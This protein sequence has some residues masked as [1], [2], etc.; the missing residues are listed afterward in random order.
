MVGARGFEPPTSCSRSRRAYRTALRPDIYC[1]VQRPIT[2]REASVTT[3]P[4]N[5]MPSKTAGREYL[6]RTPNKKAATVPVHAPV[7]G[8][9]MA[10]KIINPR[11]S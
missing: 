9:G 5:K 2:P 7:T 4:A 10:T 11:A 1:A 8:S 6:N 3:V